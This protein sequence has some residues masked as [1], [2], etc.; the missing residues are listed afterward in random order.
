[1]ETTMRIIEEARSIRAKN[2]VKLRYPLREAIIVFDGD[3]HAL[4]GIMCDEMNVKQVIFAC[5]D[6]SFM[7]KTAKPNFSKLG[8]KY[9][10][11]AQRVAELILA[12][13]LDDLIGKRLE[14]STEKV[15]EIEEED[16]T[17]EKRP[18]ADYSVG[19]VD[20]ITVALNIKQTPEL[21]AEG[22]TRE[23]IRRIQEMRKDLN[24]DMEEKIN[25]ELGIDS[26]R[27]RGWEN[28]L[29][30]ETRSMN[31]SCTQRPHG[32]HMKEWDIDGETVM[33]AINCG[34]RKE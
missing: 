23:I 19:V 21:L 6:E 17:I 28:H 7:K 16:Y 15:I 14:F 10:Q 3:L 20:G 13:P 2:N 24:L 9:K 34:S 1:M 26:S 8:P 12:T 11:N 25:A 30:K 18:S 32:Q 29:K 31:V 5:G 4:T 27:I 22:F 33:I